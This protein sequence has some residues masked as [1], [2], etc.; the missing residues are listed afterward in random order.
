MKQVMW[1]SLSLLFT[2]PL[3]ADPAEVNLTPHLS[4]K[5]AECLHPYVWGAEGREYQAHFTEG[6]TEAR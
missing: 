4:A 6:Q 1:A 2:V 3:Q 5:E